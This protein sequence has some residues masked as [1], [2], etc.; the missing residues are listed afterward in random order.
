[1]YGKLVLVGCS[2]E[3]KDDF[4]WVIETDRT[5]GLIYLRSSYFGIFGVRTPM[6]E[7]E[8]LNGDRLLI[9]SLS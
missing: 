4:Q 5:A 9:A 1:M 6:R 3:E 7:T 2:S 8:V